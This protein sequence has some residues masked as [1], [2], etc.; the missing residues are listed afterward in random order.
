[1][2]RSITIE[3]SRV[4]GIMRAQGLSLRYNGVVLWAWR[5]SDQPLP[6]QWRRPRRSTFNGLVSRGLIAG[7]P[8]SNLYEL[9][10]SGRE[11]AARELGI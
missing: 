6:R 5:D 7:V 8:G 11:A 9:T 10:E 3:Q 2:P 1:V 4:L